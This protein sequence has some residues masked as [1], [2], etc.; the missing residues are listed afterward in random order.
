MKN[1]ALE[2]IKSWKNTEGVVHSTEDLLSWI[3]ECN[4]TTYVNINE[5]SIKDSNFWFYDDEKGEI[6]NNNR[7]FFTVTGARRFEDGVFTGE[8][9]IIV[10]AEIGYLGIVCRMIDGVLNFLLQ[11]KIEPGNVN[12][13]QISP[14]I[15]ATKSNFTRAHGGKT[16][17]YFELFEHSDRYKV[18]Y[19]QVQ[20]EQAARFY[21]KRNRNTIM[22]VEDDFEIYP[23]FRWMTL[24][25]IKKLMETDNLV[26]MDTRTVLSGLPLITQ[27]LTGQEKEEI[28][29]FFGDKALYQ[30]IFCSDP[31]D[32]MPRI[33]Q[34]L[35][36][37]KMFRD[38]RLDTVSLNQ[39][40]DWTID[41]YGITCKKQAD[42]MVR[43]YDIEIA[44]REVRHWSQPLFKAIGMAT[45]GLL[46]RVKDGRRQYLVRIKPEIGSFDNAELGPSVQ[47][48]PTHDPDHDNEID[49]L[50]REKYEN[51]Q[52]VM[53]D[54]VLSEEGGRFYHEQNNNVIIE[55]AE[56]ELSDIPEDYIWT[57]YAT[58]N[59]MVQINNCLNIQLRNLL[60][61]IK[62]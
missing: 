51:K 19:D 57:D 7:S 28:E 46:S 9:P 5:C 32:T 23:N 18:I 12:C 21:K 41:D 15:Q 16:P 53:I 17:T 29:Q 30:S 13:V 49:R 1:I 25:Q 31:Q 14:T 50:F 60:S 58:L 37:Y 36:N 10:Q 2:I 42:F 40:A 22:I 6:A 20:S 48:E 59:Y 61:L 44:G 3:R 35:N 39:L 4:E 34:K 52:D 62:I 43:Y 38:I 8:Q 26:N 24:G 54:V 27:N 33:Y 55:I 11:A 47:W 56:D 45:F